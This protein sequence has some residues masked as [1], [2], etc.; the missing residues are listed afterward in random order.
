[1]KKCGFKN[2]I[3]YNH[4]VTTCS[5]FNYCFNVMF[6]YSKVSLFCVFSS[7]LVGICV[8]LMFC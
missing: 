3:V 4:P 5:Q 2:N 7:N 1:M 6:V 8:P